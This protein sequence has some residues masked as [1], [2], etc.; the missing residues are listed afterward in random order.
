M[1]IRDRQRIAAVRKIYQEVAVE[2]V[3]EISAM[4]DREEGSFI[5]HMLTKLTQSIQ[6]K[7]KLVYVNFDTKGNYHKLNPSQIILLAKTVDLDVHFDEGKSEP[8]IYI[9]DTKSGKSI[10]H[11]RPAILKTGRITHTFELDHLLD[12][13]KGAVRSTNPLNPANQQATTTANPATTN[14]ATAAPATTTPATDTATAPNNFHQEKQTRHRNTLHHPKAD[15]S[16][17]PA[18]DENI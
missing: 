13:V 18:E 15:V 17:T 3:N 9:I 7:G 16:F 5:H 10:F 1:C 14:T 6:G 8:H 12:L 11:V 2:L 4:S